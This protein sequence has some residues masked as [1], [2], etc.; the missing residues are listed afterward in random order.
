MSHYN[1]M[2]PPGA[3]V[4]PTQ[5]QNNPSPQNYGTQQQQQGYQQT[6]A[7]PTYQS[8]TQG[9]GQ[10]SQS[11]RGPGGTFGQM[12]NQAVTTSKPMLNK[13]SKT[14]SSKLGTKPSAAGMPQHLQ[15]YQNYPQHYGQQM[16][17]PT[18]A[19]S[20]TF[21][22]H[23]QQSQQQSQAPNAYAPQQSPH[24]QQN[25]VQGQTNYFA[26][27]TPPT[28]QTPYN[29]P[30]PSPQQ[31]QHTGYSDASYSHGSN[32]AGDQRPAQQGQASQA[33][34]VAQ[35]QAQNQAQYQHRPL[36]AQYNGQEIG[37]LG[38]SQHF[39]QSNP[40]S[41]HISTASPHS[42]SPPQSHWQ[43]SHSGSEQS[44]GFSY[45]QQS[46]SKAQTQSYFPNA[47]AQIQNNSS[48]QQWMPMSPTGSES[49]H[50]Q[51]APTSISPPPPT[52]SSNPPAMP[53]V[54]PQQ[55]QSSTPAPQTLTARPQAPKEFIAELPGDLGNLSFS[56]TK[57]GVTASASSPSQTSPYQAYSAPNT[58]A[59]SSPGFTIAR[60]AV[61]VS[62][63]PYAD[64][65]R[66]A[67]PLTELP[68]REF[69]VIA[70]LLFDALDRK[71]EP[72]NT[73]M[74][75]ASK[76]LRSW[77]DLTDDAVQLFSY[78]T[79][80]AFG[81][82]WSLQGIPHVMVPCQATLMPIWNFNQHSHADQL[83]LTNNQATVHTTYMPALNRAGWYKF[84]FL[85][86]MHGPDNINKLIPALCSETYKPG[87]LHHPDLN[88]R[89][90]AEAPAIQARAAELQSTAINQV[91]NETK[92][93]MLA[94]PNL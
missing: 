66:F 38:S 57:P 74:L 56:E 43:A 78:K 17:P 87:V 94:E 35:G 30:T 64:P 85:E 18:Q 40:Q 89:D 7:T 86:M 58:Q 93:A 34:T 92:A 42:P 22:P 36:Q 2:P 88:K 80:S 52:T 44:L 79:Y 37:V 70:D 59:P 76:I 41:P 61:S 47:N 46:A 5:T 11:Q 55:S 28:S 63:A 26:Q 4:P 51:V 20:Q 31:P 67:D 13:L 50:S 83:K 45:Q 32:A 1:N 72:Q 24:Q 39:Q 60:R 62:N 10:P 65:W 71:F 81:K 3:Y 25:Y 49:S 12:M 82:L 14:I 53:S 90:H 75:E 9:Y 69:Y 16:Q 8:S 91:C 33:Q 68:T 29:Q 19:Q 6:Q 77:I 21:N 23:A 84:F 73:G 54:S 27:Q 48:N 15:S